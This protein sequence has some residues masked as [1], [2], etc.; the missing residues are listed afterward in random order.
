MGMRACVSPMLYLESCFVPDEDVFGRVGQFRSENWL[1]K[2]NF[3]FTAN[4]LGA[5]QAIYDWSVKYVRERGGGKDPW[6][7]L[8]VGELKSQLDAS[9]LLLYRAVELYK[10]AQTECMVMGHEAKWLAKETLDK[11]IRWSGEICGS[12]ALFEK[13]PLERMVRDMH[14][15]MLH[16]RHDIAAQV[17][18]AAELGESYDLNR[19]R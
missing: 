6:R 10:T 19:T 12:T 11:V 15:H 16:G 3:G 5:S 13:Y 2:I 4:Y 14:V 18:G 17:V 9:R 8:R 1:G 7:Q